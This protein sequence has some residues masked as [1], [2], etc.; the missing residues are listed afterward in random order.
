MP[1]VLVVMVATTLPM[2]AALSE[3]GPVRRVTE[4]TAPASGLPVRLSVLFT[5]MRPIMRSLVKETWVVVPAATVT[6]DEADADRAYPSGELFSRTVYAP[7]VR[8]A[9]ST[10]PSEPVV[11]VASTAPPL[12][13]SSK[14][15]PFRRMPSEDFLVTL[16]SPV[17]SSKVTLADCSAYGE[18]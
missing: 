12:L 1:W 8:S 18:P 17:L 4:K 5:R 9:K 7:G 10:T 2:S 16:I 14:T 11:F 3:A 6:P 15:A 13:S